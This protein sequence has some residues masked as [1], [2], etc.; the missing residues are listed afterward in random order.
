MSLW[1]IRCVDFILC[2]DIDE[3]D[4]LNGGCEQGCEN[5]AGSHQCQCESGFM[6]AENK[7]SC[8]GMLTTHSIHLHRNF[9]VHLLSLK[10]MCS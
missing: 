8:K 10:C 5:T 4:T 1:D 7:R 3:C 2:A 6:L 9:I